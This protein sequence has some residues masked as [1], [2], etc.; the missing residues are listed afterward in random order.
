MDMS[1]YYSWNS[2]WYAF[3]L[4]NRDVDVA[5]QWDNDRDLLESPTDP[6]RILSFDAVLYREPREKAYEYALSDYIAY[7][8]LW[9]T[10]EY[11]ADPPPE[12]DETYDEAG[13]WP[14]PDGTTAILLVRSVG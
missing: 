11:L 12:F 6:G 5:T 3:K 14:L 7:K 9:K 2:F 1:Y 8:N 4:M 13:R 10:Y